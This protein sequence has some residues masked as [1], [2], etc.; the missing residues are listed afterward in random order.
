M[1]HKSGIRIGSE[2][3]IELDFYFR[4]I[5]CR[6][7]IKLPPTDKNIKYCER[8]KARI[9]DEISKNEFDYAKHFPESSRIKLFSAMPGDTVTV[10]S[11]LEQWLKAETKNV[12]PSTLNGYEKILKYNLIPAFGK[13]QLSELKRKHV[14]DWTA[15]Q[16]QTTGKTIRNILSPLRIALNTAVQQELIQSNPLVGFKVRLRDTGTTEDAD[17]F[18]TQERELI[19]GMLTGQAY[20][21]VQFAFWTGLRTSELI[22]LDWSDID[23]QRGLAVITKTFTKGMI[24]PQKS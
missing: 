9:E 17:P 1:G 12:K 7:R 2:S 4:G 5:R 14:W 11:Y 24:A 21:F 22:A 15:Q 23:W 10:E 13:L 16:E 19:L 6:E 3:S 18:S 8:L 20:N